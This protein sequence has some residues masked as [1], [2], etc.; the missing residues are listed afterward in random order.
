[1]VCAFTPMIHDFHKVRRKN[2]EGDW[3]MAI[4]GVGAGGLVFVHYGHDPT[5]FVASGS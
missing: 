4:G 2:Q 3:Q 1:M 5:A